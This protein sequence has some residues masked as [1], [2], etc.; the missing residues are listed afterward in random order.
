MALEIR[1]DPTEFVRR[2][3]LATLYLADHEA[4]VGVTAESAGRQPEPG[5]KRTLNNAEIGYIMEF[6]STIEG[7]S[8]SEVVIPPR[9][10]LRPAIADAKDK[11]VP[12]L[13]KGL[14]AALLGDVTT[15][16]AS[17][18]E[19]GLIGQMAVQRKIND[20][21]FVPLAPATIRRRQT[22]KKSPRMGTK[23]LIDF[24]AYRDSITHVVL[25]KGK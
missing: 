10:H 20:G 2:L 7:P 24:G 8:G 19:A 6:G 17:L 18:E 4:L 3:R 11:Y 25:R 9:P 5:E 21:P 13:K 22:R 12:R 1:K 15:A 16:M 14:R 23:P